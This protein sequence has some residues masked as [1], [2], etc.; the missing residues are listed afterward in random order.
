MLSR[1]RTR[2]RFS[3][4]A[5]MRDDGKR[6]EKEFP[7]AVRSYGVHQFFWNILSVAVAAKCSIVLLRK[8]RRIHSILSRFV[9]CAFNSDEK[10]TNCDGVRQQDFLTCTKLSGER[11]QMFSASTRPDASL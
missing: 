4:V 9:H 11:E 1:A 5:E 2:A 7:R 10:L 6:A 8:R 3:Y